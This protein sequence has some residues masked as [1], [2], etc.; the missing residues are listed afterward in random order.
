MY[1]CVHRH[2][3]CHPPAA[4]EV[5][6]VPRVPRDGAPSQKCGR[7]N[8]KTQYRFSR[9]NCTIIVPRTILLLFSL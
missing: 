3:S 9:T 4:L 2:C 8:F 5:V 7:A 1:Y 6:F